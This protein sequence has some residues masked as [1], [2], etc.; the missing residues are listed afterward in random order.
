[1]DLKNPAQIYFRSQ[2]MKKKLSLLSALFAL[3]FSTVSNIQAQPIKTV[4]ASGLLYEISGKN[5]KKPSY[6]FGTIHLICEKDMFPAEKLKS[7]INQTEQLMLEFD[8]DDQAVIQKAVKGSMLP[9]GKSTKDYLKPEEY[10]KIDEVY[11]NYLGISFDLL[12]KFKP[13]VSGTYLLTSPKVIGCQPPVVYDNFLAQTAVANKMPVLGLET[14]EEQIAVIDSEPLDEQIKTLNEIAENPEKSIGEFKNLYKIYLSQNPDE[15]YSFTVRHMKEQGYSQAK[16]LDSR[17][18][19]W[20]P[21]IEKNMVVK[22]SFIAVGA[23][24]LGGEKG[25]IKLL[26]AK[27]YK[28][29]P[30]GL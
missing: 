3:L 17:N 11:K 26:R 1:M 22:P 27:G 28:L 7:Y 16:M 15:L 18:V 23:G 10:A 20:I 12:Q 14:V 24:H 5:L 8:M 6:L 4:T 29:T 19:N 13:L 2:Q 30:L 21:I 25:V 9:D